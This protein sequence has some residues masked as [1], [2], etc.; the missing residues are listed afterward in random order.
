M[1]PKHRFEI[2]FARLV[3]QH[4][5]AIDRKHHSLIRRTI[6]DQLSYEPSVE[7]RNRKPLRQP[8]QLGA[9]WELRL[10]VNNEFRV[11]YDIYPEDYEVYIIAVGVKLGSQLFIS[12]EEC[13]P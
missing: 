10:G 5:V 3:A 9:T 12:G 13:E 7:T 2:V 4:L 1:T 8:S 11:F 6:E